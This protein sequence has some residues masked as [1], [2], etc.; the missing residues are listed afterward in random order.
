L[1]RVLDPSRSV[2]KVHLE[3]GQD[4]GRFW[5]MDRFSGNGT[6]VREPEAEPLRC[7]PEK[8]FRLARGTRVD[9]GEQFFIVS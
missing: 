4:S 3:F 8:R 2:S 1:V 7:Q 6:T 9:I 5:I